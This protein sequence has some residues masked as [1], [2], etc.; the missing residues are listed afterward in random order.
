MGIGDRDYMRRRREDDDDRP[1]DDSVGSKLAAWLSRFFTKY[2]RFGVWLA[3][4][5]GVAI[6]VALILARLSFN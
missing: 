3:A 1:A 4:I 2:P 6:L 5:L